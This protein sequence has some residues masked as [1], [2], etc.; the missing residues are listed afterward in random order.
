MRLQSRPVFEILR[1]RRQVQIRGHRPPWAACWRPPRGRRHG[2]DRLPQAP[3]TQ[4]PRPRYR[5]QRDTT[6]PRP[7]WGRHKSERR[8]A[9]SGRR[10]LKQAGT[11]R[12]GPGGARPRQ[13][14]TAPA[15][16]PVPAPDRSSSQSASRPPARV[17]A[18]TPG[19]AG[20]RRATATALCP[21][22]ATSGA[23]HG[24]PANPSVVPRRRLIPGT[25]IPNELRPCG[26][27]PASTAAETFPTCAQSTAPS[28]RSA[29]RFRD[30]PGSYRVATGAVA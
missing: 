10:R 11:D 2:T 19:Q 22:T 8:G 7:Q 15:G 21:T 1:S 23:R 5:R 27:S 28:R 4:W 9:W 17:P 20:Q 14:P 18:R 3:L 29:T 12:E 24:R 26:P 16:Q 30:P 6:A 13:R 25:R